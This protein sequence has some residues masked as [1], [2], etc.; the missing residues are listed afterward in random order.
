MRF[1]LTVPLLCLFSICA[2][3]Q[4][5]TGKWKGYY[6]Y[7]TSEKVT[8]QL[9]IDLDHDSLKVI[10]TTHFSFDNTIAYCNTIS[11]SRMDSIYVIETNELGKSPSKFMQGQFLRLKMRR[12]SNQVMLVGNWSNTNSPLVISG[13]VKL[14]KVPESSAYQPAELSWLSNW[15]QAWSILQK[16]YDIPSVP[17]PEMLFFDTANVYTTSAF[18][19]PDG[20]R[21]AGPQFLNEPLNWRKGK[22]G[23][24]LR[25]PNG[26]WMPVSLASFAARSEGG[27]PFFVMS[28]PAFWEA[29]HTDPRELTLNQMLTGVFLHEFSHTRQYDGF[30]KMVDSIESHHAVPGNMTDDIVQDVFKKDSVYTALFRRETAAFYAA[31]AAGSVDSAM[32][33]TRQG[34]SLL[35]ERQARYFTGKNAILKSL[36]DI[37][38]SLE[39]LGQYSAYAWLIHPA[40]ARLPAELAIKGFR[41]NGKQ[42]SQDEGLA[43][44]M[45]LT[46]ITKVSWKE[47]MFSDHPTTVTSLLRKAVAGK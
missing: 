22:L 32:Y 30:G 16:V 8:F 4:D 12:S 9:D 24:S 26:E 14:V 1:L 10:S 43:M 44:F 23:D 36:D 38:L 2:K 42:W 45:A 46:R 40:G 41:R 3:A 27:M 29:A 47:N 18:A 11:L 35:D 5:F 37:F 34:L 25:L 17:A 19:L 39:G 21:I 15:F 7:T 28:A 31:G 13:D 6:T 33:W 20:K